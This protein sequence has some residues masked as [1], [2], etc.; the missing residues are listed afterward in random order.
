[1]TEPNHDDIPV[2]K[3]DW[4]KIEDGTF[5]GLRLVLTWGCFAVMAVLAL[6]ALTGNLN[7]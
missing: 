2:E 7:Q 6:M 4:K 1:M 3:S 5:D